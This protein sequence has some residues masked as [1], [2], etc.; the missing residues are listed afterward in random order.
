MLS[1]VCLGQLLNVVHHAVQLP[2]RVD[3]GASFVVQP[4]QAFVV[5]DVSKHRLHSANALA[6]KLAAFW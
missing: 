2:L 6:V 4:G 5:P 1:Q 3:L